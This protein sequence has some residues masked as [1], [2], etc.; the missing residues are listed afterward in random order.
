MPSTSAVKRA[1]DQLERIKGSVA[2]HREKAEKV[3][4]NLISTAEVAGGAFVAG[5]L[6]AKY[7]NKSVGG[8]KLDVLAGG[9]LVAAAA[10]DAFGK[11]SEHVLEVG[12][13]MIAFAA[14]RA[15]VANS[16]K[17]LGN[18]VAGDIGAGSPYLHRVA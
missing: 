17:I 2:R 5:S 7:P 12:K 10:F 8:L 9:A 16:Q 14:G 1:L 13:G 4:T 6:M 11:Q 18:P 3:A 15:G